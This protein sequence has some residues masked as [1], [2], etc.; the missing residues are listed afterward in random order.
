MVYCTKCGSKNEEDA[1]VCVKCG[2]S[3]V[4][5]PAWRRERRR[6]T[7]QE[8]FGLPHGGLI[9]GLVI[10]IIIIL[11]GISSLPGIDIPWW[12][13]VIIIFGILILAGALYRYGRRY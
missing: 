7:E 1:A 5:R 6:P 9:A 13:F 3:L 11:A 2:A 8:C 10:G 12:P 4:A